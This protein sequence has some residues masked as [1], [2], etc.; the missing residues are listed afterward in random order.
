MGIREGS[1]IVGGVVRIVEEIQPRLWVDVASEVVKRFD[2]V[3]FVIVGGGQMLDVMRGEISD[4]GLSGRIH[5]VGQR[6]DV[7]SWLKRMQLFL[8]TSR[9]EGLPNV[10]IEA[11]GFGVPVIS[12]SAGGSEETFKDNETGRLSRIGTKEELVDLLDISLDVKWL[13]MA[14]EK[15]RSHAKQILRLDNV[16]QTLEIYEEA[17]ILKE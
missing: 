14:S 10:L 11:Q 3:H 1:R 8:L 7:S 16:F 5:L 17:K 2:D 6:D 15:S 13:Q 4:R 9:V 12:T